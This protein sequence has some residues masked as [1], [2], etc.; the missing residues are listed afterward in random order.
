MKSR[1]VYPP[2]RPHS[3]GNLSQVIFRSLPVSEILGG[4][5]KGHFCD[6][7]FA[8]VDSP[9]SLYSFSYSTKT[10]THP[11][12]HYPPGKLSTVFRN[13]L[14]EITSGIRSEW[15][16]NSLIRKIKQNIPYFISEN[17][18][19]FIECVFFSQNVSN[20]LRR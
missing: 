11:R 12:K 2:C 1:K 4:S 13:N 18:N 8:H 16:S 7:E 5:R 15:C 10:F 9:S 19:Q 20:T 6:A 17:L 14:I 3:K